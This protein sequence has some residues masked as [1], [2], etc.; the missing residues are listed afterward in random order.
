MKIQ[1]LRIAVSRLRLYARQPGAT[2]KQLMGIIDREV[3]EPLAF[4]RKLADDLLDSPRPDPE[5]AVIEHEID[6]QLGLGPGGAAAVLEVLTAAYETTAAV[7]NSIR[8]AECQCAENLLRGTSA[9]IHV[10]ARS[11]V[12]ARPNYSLVPEPHFRELGVILSQMPD[13]KLVR[14]LLPT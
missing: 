4:V 10:C 2:Y 5:C 7:S 8:S 12:N 14:H 3:L 6:T 13:K 11:M 9:A 1:R